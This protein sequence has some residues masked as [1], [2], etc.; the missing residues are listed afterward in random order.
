MKANKKIKIIIADDHAVVRSGL[1]L[2]L[3]S[4]PEFVIAGEASDGEEVIEITT[5]VKPDVIIL[6]IS[7]PKL[8]GFE[9]VKILK[10]RFPSIGVLI[11]T[12]Y[13]DEDY[14]HQMIKAGSD[15]YILKNAEKEEIFT[16]VRKVAGGERYFGPAV[17][18]K[19]V[20]EY[21]RKI[22]SPEASD[23]LQDIHLTSREIEVLKCIAQGLKSKEIAEKLYISIRTVNTHRNNIMQ[24]LNIHDTAGLVRY[25]I[26][27]KMIDLNI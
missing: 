15:A 9:A 3:E 20:R 21:V 26:E 24:K 8:N 4:C 13:D 1:R 2:L 18:E 10:S 19:I 25:A 11:L 17:S 6:D 16:A 7:M 5:A 14:I 27:N 12:I 22:I 23:I